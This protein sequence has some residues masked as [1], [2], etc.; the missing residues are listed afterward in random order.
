MSSWGVGN[1][2]PR[3]E[4]AEFKAGTSGR[5][6]CGHVSLRC[7]NPRCGACAGGPDEPP[8]C[9]APQPYMHPIDE[10]FET[11]CDA[12]LRCLSMVPRMVLDCDEAPQIAFMAR[13]RFDTDDKNYALDDKGRLVVHM[14]TGHV[15]SLA[16]AKAP[17]GM[18]ILPRAIYVKVSAANL[19][20]PFAIN[21][22]SR[23]GFASSK[24]RNADNLAP[25]KNW[26]PPLVCATEHQNQLGYCA[27]PGTYVTSMEKCYELRLHDDSPVL[28][29]AALDFTALRDE[30][31][32]TN[33][34]RPHVRQDSD[35]SPAY[36][37]IPDPYH[38]L[39]HTTAPESLGAEDVV[40]TA[41]WK[42][43]ALQRLDELQVLAAKHDYFM[44]M[45]VD[46]GTGHIIDE[47]LPSIEFQALT[48]DGLPLSAI[49]AESQ[50]Y[51]AATPQ[52]AVLFTIVY[53]P[54]PI[55]RDV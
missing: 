24:G 15:H 11:T 19:P 13:V 46:D 42:T 10:P 27:L 18:A 23:P 21:L 49:L 33:V 8:A 30:V 1:E 22:T 17:D 50:T 52:L 16:R 14:N 12:T 6:H 44:R 7:S 47:S 51:R 26:L 54:V 39:M 43:A 36:F 9:A 3:P 53:Q 32:R 29:L 48:V 45:G 31:A 37:H 35:E 2:V 28:A 38:A 41:A 5:K 55:A 4:E 34:F 40:V 25:V 20:C